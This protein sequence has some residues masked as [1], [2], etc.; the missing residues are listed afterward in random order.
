M[1]D[2]IKAPR[3]YSNES[4]PSSPYWNDIKK[5][6][7]NSKTDYPTD[8]RDHAF[9]MLLSVY[10][11][12]C[13][14]VINLRLEDIDWKTERLYLRRAKRSKLQIFP[15]SLIVGEAILRCIKEVRPNNFLI[16]EVFISMRSPYR[17]L[18][19][20]G[21]YQI[22][23]KRLKPLELNIKHHGPHALR[24]ELLYSNS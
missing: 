20:G 13:I 5:V 14:E 22:V 12:R 15:L 4:L 17:S 6:L 19:K 3:I 18:T 21:V 23:S 9:L 8:I 11:L 16:T 24:H 7:A 10:G 2:S 1:A